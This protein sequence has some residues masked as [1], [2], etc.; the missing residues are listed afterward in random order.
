MVEGQID[1]LLIIKNLWLKKKLFAFI[2]CIAFVV[3]ILIAFSIPKT[4]QTK[5][6]L[7]PEMSSTG[8]LSG[9]LG[10]LAS[11]VGF[12]FSTNGNFV[13]A[14]YPEMYPQI[15][16][17]TP[18]L[19]NL[20]NVHV[21]SKIDNRIKNITL[22][23]YL[24]KYTESPWW[25]KCI[26]FIREIFVN[27]TNNLDDNSKQEINSLCLTKE[28]DDI[29][30]TI[31]NLISCNVD[32]K[33]NIIT[34]SVTTQDAQISALLADSVQKKIQ[35]Y[36]I[37]YRTQKARNDLAYVQQLYAE[38]KKQYLIAQQKYSSYS[39][40][41]MDL[42]LEKYKMRQTLLEN[43]MQLRY[44]IYTQ[45]MQQLQIAQAKVQEITPVFTE[46]QPATVP[47]VK[48]GPKRMTIIF[49]IVLLAFIITSFYV[50]IQDANKK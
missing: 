36:V 37:N 48:Y 16:N 42:S 23:E 17:S 20:F 14:I 22:Y 44:N 12:D 31:K 33:T 26:A 46:I 28:Q 9:G 19:T 29:A 6:V 7:A 8:N 11:M 38:A 24:K 30:N 2:G 45:Y 50:L 39:D 15:I 4:Y 10:D 1:I 49:V 21:S 43:E 5:V 25:N 47:L 18:F 40:A 34:L 35:E 27:N 3:G 41:H 32:K 13:D